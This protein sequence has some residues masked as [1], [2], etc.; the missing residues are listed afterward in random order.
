MPVTSTKRHPRFTI[1][2]LVNRFP[3]R[4]FFRSR[5]G[6]GLCSESSGSASLM[7]S[8]I[9]PHSAGLGSKAY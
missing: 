8:A 1:P 6:S 5:V 3:P 7:E 4:S 2:R 9:G